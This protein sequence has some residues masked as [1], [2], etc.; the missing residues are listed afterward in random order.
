MYE[1]FL[2]RMT[3]A[4]DLMSE[5]YDAIERENRL[6]S[7]LCILSLTYVVEELRR[8]KLRICRALET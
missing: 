1:M 6:E 2:R 3:A 7:G 5:P 8:G 4:K